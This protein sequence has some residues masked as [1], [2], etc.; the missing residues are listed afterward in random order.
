MKVISQ[1]STLVYYDGIQVFEARD[2]IGG[3][4]VGTALPE[5]DYRDKYLVVGVSPEQLRQFRTSTVDLLTLILNRPEADWYIG[6]SEDALVSPL[7]L[8]RQDSVL[9]TSAFLPDAG[10]V[11]RERTTQ[12]DALSE[13]RERN[14][15]ALAIAVEPPESAAEHRIHTT[16]L[17]GLLLRIQ[18]V[19]K[20]AYSRAARDLSPAL[21]R[22]ID[23]TDAHVLDVVVPAAAGSYRMVFSPSATPGL[24]GESEVSRAL[25]I[26]D[27]LF[28]H[29]DDAHATMEIVKTYAGHLAGAYVD[30]LKFLVEIDSNLRVA[31]AEPEFTNP[32]SFSITRVEAEPIISLAN[33]VTSLTEETVV[34]SGA[35][36]KV[37]VDRRSWWLKDADHEH[38]G[39]AREGGPVLLGLTTGHQYRFTCIEE[40]TESETGREHRELHLIGYEP[41]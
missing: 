15:L 26:L 25:L 41:E 2:L 17:A 36:T 40:Y 39:D 11:L 22:R 1:F 28:E 27:R 33:G 6:Y 30:L 20:H 9:E 5:D 19:V 3:Y 32:H 35:L 24:L 34:V 10:F 12:L 18:R 14:N 13:A 8:E 21:K 16:S 4:Y 38:S 7:T 37:D 29:V 31:W 23:R